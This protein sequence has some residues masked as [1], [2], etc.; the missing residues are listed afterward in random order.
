MR[1]SIKFLF[2]AI[3]TLSALAGCKNNAKRDA[4]IFYVWGDDTEIACYEK[5]AADFTR[6]TEIKVKVQPATGSYYDNLNIKFSSKNN[7]P[8]IF[9]TESGQ[10]PAHLASKKLLNL[11]PYIDDGSLDVKTEANPTGEIELWDVNDAYRY[12][13]RE[14]GTGNYYALIK[15]WSPDFVLWYN[16]NHID[17]YNAEHNYTSGDEGFMNYPSKTVPMTWDEFLDMSYKLKKGTRYGTMLDRVP[18][19]HLMEW[20]QM[21]GSSTWTGD[22][23]YFNNQD[24][25]VL[26][27]FQFFTDLQ[28]GSKASSPII[29]PTGVGSG[30]SFANG[31]LSFC[32]FGSWAYSTYNWDS[33][34]F[35]FDCCP[36]PVPAKETALTSDDC[37]AGSCGMISLAIYKDSTLKSNAVE[38]LNYY[39][40]KGNKYMAKKGF[41]IPGNKAVANSDDFKYPEDSKLAS[42]NQYFLDVAQNYTH[43][44]VY[45]K[46]YDQEAFED[47]CGNYM[48]DYLS[49]PTG[50]TLQSVLNSIAA[51]LKRNID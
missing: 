38:F 32:F 48:S 41:N 45:N 44:I 3:I 7:A 29:G 10:L 11:Q 50:S 15:D 42:I 26:K 37:Y 16:K 30:E 25:N 24:P 9:F 23:K 27:A 18:F 51:E 34:G 13:G 39:M 6:E 43:P 47:I 4:L 19:K 21:T 33:V 20:I 12:N 5:I 36:A 17:Q 28:I 46:Y 2:P 40:T 8:D 1:R 35:E 49:N 22:N 14:I 31:N